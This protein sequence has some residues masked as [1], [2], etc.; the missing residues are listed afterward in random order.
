MILHPAVIAL[1]T[2]SLL[3]VLMIANA[4]Y[5]GWRVIDGWDLQSSAEDQLAL[6]KKTYLISTL[7]AWAFGFQILSFFLLIYVADNLHRLFVGAMCAAGTLNVNEFG[8]PALILKLLNCVLA[9]VWLILNHTDSRAPDYPLIRKKYSLL[10]AMSPLIGTEA[11]Y[12][13]AYFL[14]LKADVI[15]SCCGSIFSAGE[16]GVAAGL[17]GLPALPMEAAF[18]GIMVVALVSGVYYLLRGKGGKLFAAAGT[19]A[20]PVSVAALISFISVY[21]YELPTHHCPFCI[22]QGE[23]HYVGYLIYAAVLG[24]GVACAGVWVL[25]PC[26]A[27]PSLAEPVPLIQRR[28]TVT[29]LAFYFIFSVVVIYKMVFSDFILA[30]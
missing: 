7:M 13:G 4:A 25:M 2:G 3:V 27:I 20:F 26:R 16:E 23:Y 19:L 5:W 9:G 14:N 17:A 6:E 22:L 28:L 10:L 18:F 24:G 21:F 30:T 12:Q 11:Y 1:L 15:T 8:Y 29:A